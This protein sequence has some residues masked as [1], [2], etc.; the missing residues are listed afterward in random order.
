MF[1]ASTGRL[2]GASMAGGAGLD[3]RLRSEGAGAASSAPAPRA[4][5]KVTERFTS[6]WQLHN[7]RKHYNIHKSKF[8]KVITSY[9]RVNR[10]VT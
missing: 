9:G 3:G 4:P 5:P 10:F 8:L 2:G 6:A 1:D 7:K